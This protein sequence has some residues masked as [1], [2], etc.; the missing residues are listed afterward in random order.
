MFNQYDNSHQNAIFDLIKYSL[1]P[2]IRK[3]FF[4]N[5]SLH[6]L[7]EL[8]GGTQAPSDEI[9]FYKINVLEKHN[10]DVNSDHHIKNFI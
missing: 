2:Q 1:Q 7:A 3:K 9:N 6:Q 4:Y 8:P 5:K 10:G